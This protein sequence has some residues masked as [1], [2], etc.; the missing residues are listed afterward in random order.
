MNQ[1]QQLNVLTNVAIYARVSSQKQK[2][3]DTIESQTKALRT[4]ALQKGFD[5]PESK[6]FLD[7]G[8]SGSVL[9]RPALDEL[10]DVIRTENLNII[11]IY[12][13]DRLS[14]DYTHQLILLE[15]FRKQGVKVC[16][17]NSPPESDTPESK[18]LAHFQGIFAEYERAL[19]LDRS[20]RGRIY[21]AKQ[22]D[23]TVLPR[24]PYGYERIKVNGRAMVH[25]IEE[26]A[27]IVKEV[28]RLY[29]QECMPLSQIVEK[30]NNDKINPPKNGSKWFVSSLRTMLS[31]PAYTGTTYYGKSERCQGVSDRIQ[32]RG[33]KKMYPGNNAKRVKPE[34]EW[35]PIDMP[36]II[37]ENDFEIA[38]ERFKKNA[39][40]S[41]RNTREPGLL[42]GLIICE[43]CGQ[44]FYK[45]SRKYPKKNP[46]RRVNT[47][48]C[49]SHSKKLEKKCAA[50]PVRQD[51]LDEIVYNE[52]LKLLKNPLVVQD[53]LTRRSKEF[54]NKNEIVQKE[55]II[56][57]ELLQISRER[58][59]L[60]DGYQSGL[61]NLD[62]LSKRNRSLDTRRLDLVKAEE[63]IQAI[64]F[65]H[66][67][68]NDI[69]DSFNAILHRMQTIGS[70]LS[71]KDK[72]KLVRLLVDKV[73]I[74]GDKI[75]IVHC[76][77]P[78]LLSIE[79]RQLD[80][81]GRG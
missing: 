7:N 78:R 1:P 28:F 36:Q 3:G 60:L 14:R 12:S 16:F 62:D 25:V 40:L 74:K 27:R 17:L 55:V 67:R 75:T 33:S 71:F 41:S 69:T 45:R 32:H 42:Q 6:I 81:D 70:N 51:V 73:M 64:K 24:M 5:V 77:S 29:T 18:M 8:V 26:H 19:I 56:K 38:Q 2:E 44:P 58:D 35:L 48:L 10:R 47:Y 23:P 68:K 57:K 80:T 63:A 9:Q 4:F 52:V 76:V 54:S 72:Q 49:R 21:K 11:F 30:L 53:E 15:E 20:R 46:N 59:R 50:K 13:P 39:E 79:K 65:E 22:N 43:E 66:V 31:N 34:S 61:L 37:N